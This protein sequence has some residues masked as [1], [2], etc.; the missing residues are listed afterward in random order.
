MHSTLRSRT[1]R[2]SIARSGEYRSEVRVRLKLGQSSPSE[3]AVFSRDAIRTSGA[4][5][6]AGALFVST[7][8]V[9]SGL[10][11]LRTEFNATPSRV[12]G[13]HPPRASPSHA[14]TIT[15]NAQ[16]TIFPLR[17]IAS[18]MSHL[19]RLISHLERCPVGSR[20]M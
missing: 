10:R 12:N 15:A 6:L 11:A 3:T 13:D 2:V 19:Q 17:L 20:R 9:P 1:L 18:T 4:P 8:S 16:T 7:V 5:A 14:M